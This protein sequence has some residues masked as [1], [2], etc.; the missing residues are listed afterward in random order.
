MAHLTEQFRVVAAALIVSLALMLAFGSLATAGSHSATGPHDI[1]AIPYAWDARD[2]CN[3]VGS[4]SGTTD[5]CSDATMHASCIGDC[6][7]DVAHCSG[8]GC[9][10]FVALADAPN[11][12]DSAH[13]AWALA[14]AQCLQGLDPLVNRHPPRDDG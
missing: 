1:I 13:R 4:T 12:A 3:P 9:F 2:S 14:R 8:T 11:L 10:A 7:S 6:C 5:R